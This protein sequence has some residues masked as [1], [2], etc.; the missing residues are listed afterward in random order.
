MNSQSLRFI[1]WIHSAEL[2]FIIHCWLH[3]V[4]WAINISFCTHTF[5]QFYNRLLTVLGLYRL[6]CMRIWFELATNEW[7]FFP[8][9]LCTMVIMVYHTNLSAR[10]DAVQYLTLILVWLVVLIRIVVWI[11]K[12]RPL[13]KCVQLQGFPIDTHI[14]AQVRHML[15]VFLSSKRIHAWY[16]YAWLLI[17]V[18]ICNSISQV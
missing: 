12:K 17:I 2:C 10:S 16:K 1:Q 6:W 9:W 13:I 18:Q 14:F 4:W 5:P 7:C 3:N 11:V 15:N 8:V